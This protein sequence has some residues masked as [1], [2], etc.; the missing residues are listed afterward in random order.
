MFYVGQKLVCIAD[1]WYGPHKQFGF[2]RFRF[3]HV[4]QTETVYTIRKINRHNHFPDRLVILLCEVVH[5]KRPEFA[6][7][8]PEIF[9][10]LLDKPTDISIFTEMLN[11]NNLELV[12]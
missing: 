12:K 11:T 3:D 9:R 8:P 7:F 1:S 2:K 10:P 6:G 5:P 4:L